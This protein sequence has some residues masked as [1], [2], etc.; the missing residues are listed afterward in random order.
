VAEESINIGASSFV[1][2]RRQQI[3]HH[4]RHGYEIWKRA[5]RQ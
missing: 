2:I 5:W 1:D 3:A 4:G